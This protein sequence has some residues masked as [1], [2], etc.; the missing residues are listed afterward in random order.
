[1]V[2]PA[3]VA[4]VRATGYEQVEDLDAFLA[5]YWCALHLSAAGLA[6]LLV[7]DDPPGKGYLA[8]A[9]RLTAARRPAQEIISGEYGAPVPEGEDADDDY[10]E[11]IP[12]MGRPLVAGRDHPS[13]PR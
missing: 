9:R 1:M 13:W 7:G 3:P 2:V 5:A 10:D 12:D 6:E 11:P 8:T 4:L